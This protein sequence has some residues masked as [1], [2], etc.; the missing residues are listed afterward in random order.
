ML[1]RSGFDQVRIGPAYDTFGGAT[2]ES[3][4]RAFAVYGY[5]FLARCRDEVSGDG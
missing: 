3:N 4:A 5:D 2:G 1:E